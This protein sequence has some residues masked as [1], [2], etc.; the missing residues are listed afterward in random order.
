MRTEGNISSIHPYVFCMFSIVLTM[1]VIPC[2]RATGASSAVIVTFDGLCFWSRVPRFPFIH[3]LCEYENYLGEAL[4]SLNLDP[5]CE[6]VPFSWSRDTRD[7]VEVVTAES[8]KGWMRILED[9]YSEAQEQGKRFIVVSHSWGTFLAYVALS[10][11]SSGYDGGTPVHCDLYITLGSPLGTQHVND[12]SPN[13]DGTVLSYVWE[14]LREFDSILD[15][16]DRPNA[17]TWVNYW[18]WGDEFSGPLRKQ[19]PYVQDNSVDWIF[20]SVRQLREIQ[21]LW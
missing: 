11:A 17:E 6:I 2:S 16:D 13:L 12:P 5:G 3:D 20:S 19:A 1:S 21:Q 15:P 7:T 8:E 18:A 14:K 10:L 9:Q 4:E